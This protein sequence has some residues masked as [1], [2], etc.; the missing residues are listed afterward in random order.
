MFSQGWLV[1]S[2]HSVTH[3][4]HC[5]TQEP[6]ILCLSLH[7]C[8][9]SADV[10]SLLAKEQWS[11]HTQPTVTAEAGEF[12]LVLAEHDLLLSTDWVRGRRFRGY[13]GDQLSVKRDNFNPLGLFNVLRSYMCHIYSVVPWHWIWALTAL[14]FVLHGPDIL[15]RGHRN[16]VKYNLLCLLC[17]AVCSFK[18]PG[19]YFPWLEICLGM[20]WYSYFLVVYHI[21]LKTAKPLDIIFFVVKMTDDITFPVCICLQCT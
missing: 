18:A 11:K 15:T 20:L 17:T 3:K 19:F 2:T 14:I 10:C 8:P 21:V 9:P 16:N 6:D 5:H 1:W 7:I 4:C 12:T 13:G